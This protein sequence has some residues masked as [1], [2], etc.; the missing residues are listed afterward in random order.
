MQET[1]SQ[2]SRKILKNKVRLEHELDVKITNKGK[3]LFV[4]GEGEQEYLA[5][6]VIEAIDLGFKIVQALLLIQ[7]DFILEKINIKDI[8]KRNDLERVRGRIIGT[9]GRTKKIIENLSDCFISLHDNVVGIIGLTDNI[10]KAI[11]ALTS[12]I[13][14]SKQNRVYSSLERKNIKEK[15]SLNEDLGLKG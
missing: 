13:Q 5:I 10:E 12:I 2:N 14:G 4:E 8:T 7:D 11:Q 3:V 15:L 1:Y 6:Q 9:D